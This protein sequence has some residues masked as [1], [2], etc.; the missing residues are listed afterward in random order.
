MQLQ[1]VNIRKIIKT[2]GSTTTT[3][4]TTMITILALTR[5]IISKTGSKWK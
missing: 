1:T 3:P 2:I 4:L 5:V